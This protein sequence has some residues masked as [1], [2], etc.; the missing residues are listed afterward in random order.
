MFLSVL[1]PGKVKLLKFSVLPCNWRLEDGA[2]KV[3]KERQ[4]RWVV[5]AK[6]LHGW[7]RSKNPGNSPIASYILLFSCVPS[8]ASARRNERF[9]ELYTVTLV[10]CC[11]I[12]FPK[13]GDICKGRR[14]GVPF[15]PPCGFANASACLYFCPWP[16]LPGTLGGFSGLRLGR[17]SVRL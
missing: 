9:K 17:L 2:R 13:S 4:P 10:Q 15:H 14:E 1:F 3:S 6:L 7:F 12:W 8:H 16:L 5:P 11:G